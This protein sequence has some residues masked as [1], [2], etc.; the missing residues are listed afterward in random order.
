MPARRAPT[1]PFV[2]LGILLA[3]MGGVVGA[4]VES[5]PGAELGALIGAALVGSIGL[6]IGVWYER[7]FRLGNR[8]P[9]GFLGGAVIGLLGGACAGAAIGAASLAYLGSI[10]GAIL[11]S[12]LGWLLGRL[13]LPRF[14]PLAM[15][16]CGA[17]AGTLLLTLLTDWAAALRGLGYGLLVGVLAAVAL[18]GGAMAYLTA[19]FRFEDGKG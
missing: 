11:G 1:H 10:P 15:T 2:L 16:F 5:L 4:A 9:P 12:V 14:G 18:V 19:V 6:F 8:L 7:M 3:L 17:G 13:R